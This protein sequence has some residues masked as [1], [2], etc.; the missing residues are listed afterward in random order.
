MDNVKG[1]SGLLSV[2]EY[3]AA[4]DRIKWRAIT[5]EAPRLKYELLVSDNR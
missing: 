3:R 4:Q 5:E 2:E 1:E